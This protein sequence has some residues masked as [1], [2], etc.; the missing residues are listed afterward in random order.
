MA[1]AFAM[2]VAVAAAWGVGVL[3]DIKLGVARVVGRRQVLSKDMIKLIGTS[4]ARALVRAK[5]FKSK[6][7]LEAFVIKVLKAFK[8]IKVFTEIE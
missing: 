1:L 7:S 5:A 8:S 4:I 2:A 3:L 6:V